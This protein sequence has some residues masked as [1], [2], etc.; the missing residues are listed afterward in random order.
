MGMNRFKLP[1]LLGL[2]LGLALGLV[3]RADL[4]GSLQPPV[5][6]H[7]ADALEV[8]GSELLL[9]ADLSFATTEPFEAS[10]PGHTAWW[11]WTVPTNG[12]YQWNTTGSAGPVAV[13]VWGRDGFGQ[14]VLRANSPDL[15]T[16]SNTIVP[17][18]NGSFTARADETLWLQAS[19]RTERWL[20]G[21]QAI[22]WQFEGDPLGTNYHPFGTNYPAR[23]TLQR[24]LTPPP[25]ND[26]FAGRIPLSGTNVSFN[27]RLDSATA[28]DGE[29][30]LPGDSLQRTAWWTWQASGNGTARLRSVGSTGAPVIGVYQAGPFFALQRVATSATE[31]GNQ[32][33]REWRGREVLE[34]DT[35]AGTRY[36]IQLDRYPYNPEDAE[37]LL[38]LT[39]TPA[40]DHDDLANAQLIEGTDFQLTVDNFGATRR[41][42]DPEIPGQSG[43][44]SVWYRW[45]APGQG[46][47]QVTKNAPLRF[48]EP[49][50]EVLPS[51]G[52]W[53]YG[54]I[55]LIAD[56]FPCDA[57]ADLNPLP[58]FEPVFGLYSAIRTGDGQLSVGHLGHGTNTAVAEV[59][60]ETLIQMDG[61]AG[62]SGTATM[63]LLF[64]PP[65]V[66]GEV[67]SRIILPS[68]P[69]RVGGRTF[70]ART[71]FGHPISGR[72]AWW[73]WTAPAAGDWV[74]RPRTL[75]E[76]HRLWLQRGAGASST[77]TR[78]TTG[79][80]LVFSAAAGEVFQLAAVA[81]QGFG[82]NVGF[83]LHP[84]VAP[85]VVMERRH[86]VRDGAWT[87]LDT[88]QWPNGFDL[89]RV[90]ESSVDLV[91]W[92]PAPSLDDWRFAWRVNEG[93]PRRFYRMRLVTE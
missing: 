82:N 55:R 26:A 3:G 66:N 40:P 15:L 49:A 52:P 9:E 38:E 45:A 93:E 7:F 35:A 14:L 72:A 36:E 43:A 89:P 91:N 60:G 23:I 54:W 30:R 25:S 61:V 59:T 84:A 65:P 41:I 51:G 70:A 58:F 64:T 53:S 5:N 63:N 32:C 75:P 31:F 16:A 47:L 24:S 73:E 62:T 29:P 2:W 17:L 39:F 90:F 20:G 22:D 74:L 77:G 56:V 87:M 44:G 92:T 46:I 81:T 34:W 33:Y 10:Y 18:R 28:E 27:A 12:T 8:T 13:T 48:A 4:A 83:E 79:Q 67:A 50:F 86:E 42:G 1:G 57:I 21:I 6:D 78:F 68:T 11:K 88:F 69:V 71:I 76:H 85:T 80:P 19:P 37:Y